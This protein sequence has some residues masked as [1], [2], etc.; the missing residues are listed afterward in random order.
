MPFQLIN[1][2]SVS[3]LRGSFVR[4]DAGRG[5]QGA[6]RGV[7]GTGPRTRTSPPTTTKVIK[8]PPNI[9][10]AEEAQGHV[11]AAGKVSPEI[12]A[13]FKNLIGRK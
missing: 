9:I 2:L 8:A 13:F 11:D 3:M 10:L 1:N 4:R 5:G 6:A 12:V 7:E